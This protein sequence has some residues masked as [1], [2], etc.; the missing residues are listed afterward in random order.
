M[1][2]I[3]QGDSN[4][5]FLQ[6]VW[7]KSEDLITNPGVSW[8]TPEGGLMNLLCNRN[9]STRLNPKN[10]WGPD[11]SHRLPRMREGTAA[12]TTQR[13]RVGGVL[14][15]PTF[16]LSAP[17]QSYH[18]PINR[19]VKWF[20]SRFFRE[21]QRRALDKNSGDRKKSVFPT[22]SVVAQAPMEEGK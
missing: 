2:V 19:D 14:S 7:K 1:S 18:V 20:E 9:R 3:Q 21:R 10:V 15:S 11:T 16:Y 17:K 4:F 13:G 6:Q 22:A 8:L 5:W 12:V